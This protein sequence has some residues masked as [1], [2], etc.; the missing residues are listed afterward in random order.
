MATKARATLVAQIIALI[1]SNGNREVNA[2]KVRQVLNDAVD[3]HF[4]LITDDSD[5]IIEGITK[6]LMTVAERTKLGGI[7]TGATGDQTGAEIK[8]LYELEINAF[9]DALFTK[10]GNIEALADVTDTANV[11]VA[12][13]LMDSEVDADLKTF[14]LPANTTISIFGAS[15]IDD[16]NA[17]AARTTL[18]LIIGTDVQAWSAVLDATTASF[19]TADETKLDGIET[20]AQVNTVN[21]VFGRTGSIIAVSGDYSDALIT[22]TSSVDGAFVDDALNRLDSEPWTL[23]NLKTLIPFDVSGQNTGPTGIYFTDDGLRLYMSEFSTETVFSYTLTIP[24]DQTTAVYDNKSFATTANA[25]NAQGVW[26][27]NDGKKMFTSR[28]QA[29]PASILEYNLSTAFDITT[30]VFSTSLNVSAQTTNPRDIF[31]RRDGLRLYIPDNTA[32]RILQFNLTT[33]YDLTTAS[34]TTSGDTS[35]EVVGDMDV[36]IKDDGLRA[37]VVDFSNGKVFSYD[38]TTAWDISTMV[39][40]GVSTASLGAASSI[41]AV[42]F[43]KHGA[44]FFI[45]DAG[46]DELKAFEV[47]EQNNNIYSD[48]ERQRVISNLVTQGLDIPSATITDIGAAESSFVSIT[49]TTTITS[50][51]TTETK[52]HMWLEFTGILT[53]TQNAASLILPTGANIITAAGDTCEAIRLSSG[54]GN[55][56]VIN[57]QRADGTPLDVAYL[58]RTASSLQA[59]TDAGALTIAHNLSGTPTNWYVLLRCKTAELNYSVGDKLRASFTQDSANNQGVSVVPDATNLEIRFGSGSGA[60]SSVF[61]VINKTTGAGANITNANWE[62]IFVAEL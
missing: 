25:Q 13:A 21:S 28:S 2:T 29:T 30:A 24:W 40:D 39:A 43:K 42:F 5:D 50:F 44:T 58:K 16:A 4:N 51:G 3:S 53:L 12:G 35:G 6:L 46:T 27:S 26:L 48:V 10:L 8:A 36:F 15:I 14:A 22:N 56:I 62:V 60:G 47:A 34:F 20:G 31:F 45:A 52:A 38:L 1:T 19:T 54:A 49:G 33:P 17:S 32:N 9:T 57:Y 41:N 18:E 23:N 59:I 55:W 37:F 61:T 7:E 11:T